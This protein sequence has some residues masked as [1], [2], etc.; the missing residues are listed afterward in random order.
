MTTWQRRMKEDAAIN[1]WKK[2]PV[3]PEKDKIQIKLQFKI[4]LT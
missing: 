3:D 4:L 1:R 2:I